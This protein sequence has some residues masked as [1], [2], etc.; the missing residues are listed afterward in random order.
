MAGAQGRGLNMIFEKRDPSEGI[1]LMTV[2]KIT[3]FNWCS[4]ADCDNPY[5]QI[6]IDGLVLDG[7]GEAMPAHIED[8]IG[9]DDSVK[10]DE[11]VR[12]YTPGSLH[13]VESHTFHFMEGELFFWHPTKT[14]PVTCMT[15]ELHHDINQ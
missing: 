7:T 2:I 8:S 6:S 4:H 15:M 11:L 3:D 10:V 1:N 14:C 9:Y 13:W 5:L 12:L